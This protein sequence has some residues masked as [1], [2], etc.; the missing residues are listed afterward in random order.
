MQKL[1]VLSVAVSLGLVGCQSPTWNTARNVRPGDAFRQADPS[2]FYAE[3]LHAVLLE[4]GIEH[5]VVTYQYHYYTNHYEEAVGTRTAV[6]YCDNVNTHYPW[7]LM[8]DRTATPFW[9]PRGE[10]DKQISFYCRR[11]AEVIEKKH[12]PARGEGGKAVL[13]LKRSAQQVQFRGSV[14]QRPPQPQPRVHVAARTSPAGKTVATNPVEKKSAPAMREARLEKLF[15]F[16]NGTVYDPTSPIDR[17]KMAQLEH[18][19]LGMETNGGRAFRHGVDGGR[20][21]EPF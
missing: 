18:G 15:H 14:A 10:L 2:A 13:P 11:K 12:Y 9:L 16:R 6:V 8:D 19:L 7:W 20:N 17:R 3:K 5:Y 1:L 4:Q 21:S